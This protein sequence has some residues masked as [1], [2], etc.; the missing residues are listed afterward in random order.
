ME[1]AL[2]IFSLLIIIF[3][4]GKRT[5]TSNEI[6]LRKVPAI[7]NPDS[8]NYIGS[9]EI[10]KW[11]TAYIID[12]TGKLDTKKTIE[13]LDALHY[14][15]TEEKW[16]DRTKGCYYQS[17]KD[18]DL[19]VIQILTGIYCTSTN[20]PYIILLTINKKNSFIV[21]CMAYTSYYNKEAKSCPGIPLLFDNNFEFE[22]FG[23][24]YSMTLASLEYENEL[25]YKLVFNDS[26]DEIGQLHHS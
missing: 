20:D 9:E 7:F 15:V 11:C 18:P 2:Y 14:K 16:R 12:T 21:K 13:L 6:P 17:L 25:S 26:L 10:K 1:K 5:T 23:N 3:S 24:Y 19:C 22:R 8:C 4:C